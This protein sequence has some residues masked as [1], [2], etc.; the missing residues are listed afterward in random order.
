MTDKKAASQKTFEEAKA[1]LKTKLEQEK[2]QKF[3]ED[4]M[5]KLKKEYKVKEYPEHLKAAMPNDQVHQ[6]A[7]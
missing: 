4:L 7:K 5:A 1:G 2:Q 6:G 3:M